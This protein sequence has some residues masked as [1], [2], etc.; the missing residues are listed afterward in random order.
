MVLIYKNVD[1]ETAL[2]PVKFSENKNITYLTAAN[3]DAKKAMEL[4]NQ[5]NK[6]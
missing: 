3:N 2:I 4:Y 1:L 5:Y 6:I